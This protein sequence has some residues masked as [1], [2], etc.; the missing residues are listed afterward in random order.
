MNTS[1]IKKYTCHFYFFASMLLTLYSQNICAQQKRD[2]LNLPKEYHFSVKKDI[3]EKQVAL[4]SYEA[5]D[6]QTKQRPFEIMVTV[7]MDD[8]VIKKSMDEQIQSIFQKIKT[9]VPAAVLT[10]V[11][12]EKNNKKLYTITDKTENDSHSILILMQKNT[13]AFF[14][15]EMETTQA[16]LK[17]VSMKRW[18]DI[19]WNADYNSLDLK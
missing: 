7:I 16:E 12:E 6:P 4:I 10:T 2:F 14:M 3:T 13:E 15:I 19:F 17:K 18:E 1:G 9:D 8:A 5:T 11:K